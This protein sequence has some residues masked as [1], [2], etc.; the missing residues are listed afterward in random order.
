MKCRL[1]PKLFNSLYY[2]SHLLL[3][4]KERFHFYRTLLA[5]NR[6]HLIFL[7]LS[8]FIVQQKV[9]YFVCVLNIL[10]HNLKIIG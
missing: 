3:L 8:C 2:F 6:D 5:T 1:G 4:Q 10:E 7:F 9:R